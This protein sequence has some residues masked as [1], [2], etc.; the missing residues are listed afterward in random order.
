MG[1]TL[2]KQ[3][4][5][6]GQCK[7]L[8][9]EY[10]YRDKQK[11]DGYYS[12]C[13]S[14][15]A[16]NVTNKRLGI[17]KPLLHKFPLS[18]IICSI[19]G[20]TLPATPEFFSRHKWSHSGLRS[21]CKMCVRRYRQENREKI[22]QKQKEWST[23]NKEKHNQLKAKWVK[24]NREIAR[25]HARNARKRVD[26]RLRSLYVTRREARKRNLPDTM[27]LEQWT[28]C[29]DYFNGCCAVCGRQLKD[30]FGTHTV[31]EDHWIPLASPDCPGTVATNIIPLCHGIDGCNNKKY[32]KMPD[33]WLKQEY[34]TRKAN[35][36]L[37][38]IN[39][40]FEWVKSQSEKAA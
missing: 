19:C 23:K 9:P 32:S 5:Q 27:T 8:T 12:S 18:E 3:C 6:C 13:K 14:C 7:P 20:N 39:A 16:E 21:D 15:I 30:L 33:V 38:R 22:G 10:W 29:L 4:S 26:K 2:L 35:E 11:S 28:Q 34:G 1:N 24:E 17:A 36:I 40:Y 31:A 37:A 25:Q